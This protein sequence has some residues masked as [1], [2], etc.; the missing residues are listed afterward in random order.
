MSLEEVKRIGFEIAVL[1]Q[2]GLDTNNPDQKYTLKSLHGTFSGLHLVCLMYVAFKQIAT[3]QSIGFDL[4]KE[5]EVARSLFPG[6][7]ENLP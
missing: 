1:G 7:Q 5:Y 3:E 6:D 2:R 4:S